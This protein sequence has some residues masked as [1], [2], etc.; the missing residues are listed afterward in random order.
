MTQQIKW[1]TTQEMATHL[2]IHKTTLLDLRRLTKTF[3][4]GRD[5]R[6]AGL[7]SKRGTLQ[8]HPI[9]AEEAFSNSKRIPVASVETFAGV[10]Q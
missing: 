3:K 1:L 8:W 10:N 9:K 7:S 6:R 4:E 5:F 2:G